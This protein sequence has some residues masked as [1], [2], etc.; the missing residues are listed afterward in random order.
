MRERATCEQA[1]NGYK[2]LTRLRDD[3]GTA[4]ELA[5]EAKDEEF[6]R[7]AVRALDELYR[8]LEKQEFFCKMSGEFDKNSAIIEINAGAGGTEAQD[9]ANML[10]RMYTRWAE[11]KG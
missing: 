6:V 8:Q 11:R 9:W 10:L 3:A 7:E 4:L 2:E 5:D 1:V